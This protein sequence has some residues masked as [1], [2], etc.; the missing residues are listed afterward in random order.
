MKPGGGG[1]PPKQIE[2]AL[3]SSFGSVDACVL[4]P[5]TRLRVLS[6]SAIRS[7]YK[8][9]KD[10]AVSQFG[11]GWAWLVHGEDGKLKIVKTPN[12]VS[13]ICYGQVPLLTCDVW[14]HAYYLDYQV[15]VSINAA[16]LRADAFAFIRACRTSEATSC[17]RSWTT[18]STGSSWSRTCASPSCEQ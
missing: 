12:A 16:C 7:F 9:F 10:A 6:A 15:R 8:Q 17:R 18:W 3:A 1:A 13:P 2:E 4:A 5:A 11:S 14:E